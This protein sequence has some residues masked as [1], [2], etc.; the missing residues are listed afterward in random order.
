[1]RAEE[2]GGYVED[3]RGRERGEALELGAGRSAGEVDRLVHDAARDAPSA[4]DLALRDENGEKVN[5]ERI[6]RA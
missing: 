6:E 5:C 1:M 3:P 2:G 4:R